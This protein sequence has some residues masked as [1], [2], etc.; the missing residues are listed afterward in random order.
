MVKASK[1]LN[2]IKQ[3]NTEG[4]ESFSVTSQMRRSN[5]NVF[6]HLQHFSHYH[7]LFAVV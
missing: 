7:S 4:K 3:A 6:R 1:N 5:Q 2:D